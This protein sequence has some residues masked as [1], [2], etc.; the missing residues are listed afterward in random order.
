MNTT[1]MEISNLL[2]ANDPEELKRLLKLYSSNKM[3]R[4]K[5]I[6]TLLNDNIFNL[7]KIEAEE[8]SNITRTIFDSYLKTIG[9]SLEKIDEE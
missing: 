8:T 2:L 7:E 1:E 6:K 9:L 5:L 3:S 4:R